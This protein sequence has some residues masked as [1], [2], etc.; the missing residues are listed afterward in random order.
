MSSEKEHSLVRCLVL[1]IRL[2]YAFQKVFILG[3]DPTSDSQNVLMVGI[4]PAYKET[5]VLTRY[6]IA[7][8]P[9][10]NNH[11]VACIGHLYC[12]GCNTH[13]D[14]LPRNISKSLGYVILI[15]VTSPSTMRMG[16]SGRY[17]LTTPQ[18]S[19]GA[20]A[21]SSKPRSKARRNIF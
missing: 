11:K 15:L 12:P 20:K 18:S 2:C 13:L 9:N 8:H 19:V 3:I 14:A 6:A 21:G 7:L 4:D 1:A 5:P 16:T 10:H 17:F